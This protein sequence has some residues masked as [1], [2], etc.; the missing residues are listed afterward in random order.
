MSTF[1]KLGFLVLCWSIAALAQNP[2]ENAK[3]FSA[4]IVVSAAAM[5]TH[6]AQGSMKVY[7]SGDKMRTEVPGGRGY[8]ITELSQHTSYM[9]MNAMC[10][11]MKSQPQQNPFA[12]A[13][14]ASVERS[15]AGTDTVDG[16]ACKVENLMVTPH[17]GKPT[18]MKVWEAED[19]KGFPVKVETQTDKGPVTIEYKDISFD[20]PAASLFAH[21]ENCQQMPTMSGGMPH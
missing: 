13:S 12:Q 17:N 9:V 18:K 20:A 7:K 10:M 1:S 8:V 4:T 6:G 2:F 3:Q 5:E 21:P 14:D 19:L 11:Q 15:S 16:H